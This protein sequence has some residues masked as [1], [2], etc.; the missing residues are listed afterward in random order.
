MQ[1]PGSGQ[2][3]AA[4]GFTLLE[5]VIVLAILAIVLG[6]M[7]PMGLQLFQAE[8]G[9]AVETELRTIYAAI[10]GDPARGVFG[11]VG[12]VG[13]YPVSLLDLVV[14][15]TDEAGT[16]VSGWRGPYLQ[17]PRVENGSLLDPYGRPYEYYLVSGTDA[18]DRLAII[19]RGLDG[20]STNSAA[21]PNVATQYTG[22]SPVDP[23]YAGGA[24]N[25][26]NVIFPPPRSTVALNVKIDG[27][28]GFNI[29][30]RDSNSQVNAFVPACPELYTITATSVA[31]GTVEANVRYMQ[32]LT[33]KLIQGQYRVTITPRGWTTPA[34]SETLTVW[35]GAPVTRVLNLTGLDSSGTPR[36]ILTVRNATTRELEVFEF[37]KRLAS[38]DGER[39]I[40]GG[41]TRT[42]T[43]R[44][45]AQI[46]IREKKTDTVV[47]QFV[48]PYLD[49]TRV[50]GG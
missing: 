37:D 43:P 4:G 14:P 33:F 46:F 29:L 5:V 11:Y 31:R 7:V 47:D 1:R 6:V 3:G 13:S 42:F 45:C 30:N 16:P 15:L 28:V 49:T 9:S 27:N 39:Y 35:P 17:N 24:G 19:S 41:Q 26:D 21:A 22:P 23:A 38:A 10:V 32:G 25:R 40:D 34:W 50:E 12:D 48:M 2:P 44:G 8:R 36:F 18:W 20:L